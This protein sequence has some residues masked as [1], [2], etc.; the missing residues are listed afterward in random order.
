[1]KIGNKIIELRKKAKLTQ[2]Q[3]AEK[4]SVTRQTISNWENSITAPDIN[5]ALALANLFQ[6]TINDLLDEKLEVQC[7]S[8]NSILQKLI[9][10]ECFLDLDEEDEDYRINSWTL[11]KIL[12]V[13][14]YYLKFEFTYG[15]ETVRKM[16]DLNMVHSF[17]IETK[18]SEMRKESK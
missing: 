2:K 4:M 14:D 5:Q 13:D 15:K 9:G 7:K 16:I 3:L 10:K 6:V 1:M 11:C 17:R 12:S 18:L 8:S